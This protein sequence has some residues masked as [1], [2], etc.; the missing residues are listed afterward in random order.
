MVEWNI[1]TNSIEAKSHNQP[2]ELS[3]TGDARVKNSL[4][5]G[6]KSDSYILATVYTAPCDLIVMAWCTASDASA[7]LYGYSDSVDATTA[8][9]LQS[10]QWN[11]YAQAI[12]FPVRKGDFWQVVSS[13][14]T[15]I[16][17]LELGG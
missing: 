16:R 12:T 8:I 3:S 11:T 10:H 7:S 13:R 1:I 5:F 6:A 15:E 9:I 17:T 4:L 2:L 14:T